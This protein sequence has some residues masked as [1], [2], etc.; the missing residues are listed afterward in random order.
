MIIAIDGPSGTGK[1]T[2]AKGVAKKLGITFFD[3]GAMYRSMA[4]WVLKVGVDPSDEE[5]V[6][7]QIPSFRYV[8]ETSSTRGRIYKV[9]GIDVSEAIRTPQI[10]AAA[11]KISTYAEVR[12]ALVKIQREFG[13]GN[14]AVFEGRDM[15][16]V[17][18]PH[19]DVKVFLTADPK[20]R[21]ERR[22]QELLT[23]FPDLEQS[24]THEQILTDLE[25]R[26][27]SDSTRA[28]SPL[29]R[30]SDAVLIDTSRLSSAEA[31]DQVVAL[32]RACKKRS[33]MGLFYG[34]VLRTAR[35]FL[36]LFYHFRVFGVEHFKPGAAIIA[37][38]HASHLDP[39]VV[40]VSCPQEV[41]FLAKESLFRVPLLGS[42][43][44]RLNSHPVARSPSDAS[45]FR[46]LIDLL[47]AGHK[48]IVF[49]EGKRSVDGALQPIERGLPFLVRQAR[50][51]VQPVYVHGTFAA[52]PPG[53]KFPKLWGR[54]LCVFGSPIEWEEFEGLDKRDAERRILERMAGALKAL[55]AWVEAGARGT[56]P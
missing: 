23:K 54:I 14:N 9:D 37:S 47:H 11:S 20:I 43:I 30:A 7:Q 25:K 16:T 13:N 24:L 15:G 56:P 28:I 3:T 1:S 41:H 27:H 29:K 12:K 33:G 38:N 32:V 46:L 10:S 5:R 44:R 49:P 31:I 39:P 4:W 6:K 36:G 2:V 52:W 21:A 19:A 26:D 42:L 35:F 40:S 55:K 22:Y 17:V 45:T 34:A 8:I 51:R 53:K 18:F 50:C 48:V